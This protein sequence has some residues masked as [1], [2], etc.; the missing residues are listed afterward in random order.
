MEMRYLRSEETTDGRRLDYVSPN[1]IGRLHFACDDRG[2]NTLNRLWWRRE[3]GSLTPVVNRVSLER[4]ESLS[5]RRN[6]DSLDKNS[7][8]WDELS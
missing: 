4:N 5:P 6:L 1:N 8:F 7:G 2:I 3:D